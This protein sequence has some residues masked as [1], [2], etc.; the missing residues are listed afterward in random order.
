LRE[1]KN[2]GELDEERAM[3]EELCKERAIREQTM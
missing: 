2:V 3:R 1:K